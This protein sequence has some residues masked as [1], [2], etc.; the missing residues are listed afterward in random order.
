MLALYL[1]RDDNSEKDESGL[2]REQ[3]K[4]SGNEIFY[5]TGSCQHYFRE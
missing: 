3:T 2:D 4:S 5:V 1:G